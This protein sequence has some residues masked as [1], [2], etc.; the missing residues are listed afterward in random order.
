MQDDKIENIID[1]VRDLAS[2][3]DDMT[4]IGLDGIANRLESL[5]ATVATAD[6]TAAGAA[7]LPT[8]QKAALPTGQGEAAGEERETMSRAEAVRTLMELQALEARAG[9]R[10]N[11]EALE[12]AINYIVKRHRD[13]CRNKA[14]RRAAARLNDFAQSRRAA[15]GGA[16]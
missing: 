1:D 12:M 15:E 4:R 11:T 6:A 2:V 14:K 8:G 5:V 13:T 7:A 9:R 16:R 10:N 3:Y